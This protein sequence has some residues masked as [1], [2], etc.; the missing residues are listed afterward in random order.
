MD[1]L[2]RK[3]QYFPGLAGSAVS[4]LAGARQYPAKPVTFV[5]APA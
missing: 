3:L 2:M 4:I 5:V 1:P